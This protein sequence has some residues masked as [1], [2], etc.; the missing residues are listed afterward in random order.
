[1]KAGSNSNGNESSTQYLLRS[2]R[3]GDYNIFADIPTTLYNIFAD[4]P[5]TLYNIYNKGKKQL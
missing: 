3:L 2:E 1:L 4:I 5:P